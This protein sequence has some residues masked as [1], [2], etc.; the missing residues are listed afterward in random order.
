MW[1]VEVEMAF[2]EL[3]VSLLDCKVC[4]TP[5][6]LPKSDQTLNLSKNNISIVDGLKAVLQIPSH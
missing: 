5:G 4:I 6:C 1:M 3:K 2:A